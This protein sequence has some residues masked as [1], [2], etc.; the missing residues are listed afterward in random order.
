MDQAFQLVHGAFQETKKAMPDLPEIEET[1]VIEGKEKHKQCSP[2]ILDMGSK[3][4]CWN[5]WI[6]F[7]M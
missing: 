7:E 4:D 2:L 5:T 3:M 6:V 1:T